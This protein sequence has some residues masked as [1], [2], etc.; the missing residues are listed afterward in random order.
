MIPRVR[1]PFS[2]LYDLTALLPINIYNAATA[3]PLRSAGGAAG[4][5]TFGR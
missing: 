3:F 2:S 5:S 1:A 4:E